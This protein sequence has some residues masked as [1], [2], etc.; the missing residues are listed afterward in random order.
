MRHATLATVILAASLA[1]AAPARAA[2]ES[3][4]KSKTDAAEA[5]SPACRFCGS[6]CGLRAVCVCEPVT[7][8]K[9]KTTYSMKC[10]PVCVPG[11]RCLHHATGQIAGA[12][13][14]GPAC[15]G[16]CGNATVRTKK[17]LLKEVTDEELDAIEH[18][19]EY[20]CCHCAG[21]DA[22]P[23]CSSCAGH[24]PLVGH[25]RP[26]WRRLLPW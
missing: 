5:E 23:T 17:V 15:D 1:A 13:C 12:G 4:K 8:K 24:G 2:E 22:A 20:V 26:W 9:S 21:G 18:K 25:A 16:C 6:G 14:A 11:P 7:K 19:V 3:G 10:E